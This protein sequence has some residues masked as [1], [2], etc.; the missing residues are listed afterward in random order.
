MTLKFDIPR[1]DKELIDKA[2][3]VKQAY[4]NNCQTNNSQ[5][6]KAINFMAEALRNNTDKILEANKNDYKIA[7]E[8]GISKALLS[9][10]KLSKDKLDLGINGV[11]QVGKLRDPIGELQI[12]KEL[13]INPDLSL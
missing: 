7:E 5:R 10:L 4:L 3:K 11:R 2:K 12:N 9:R 8:K 6:I 1:P 13:S